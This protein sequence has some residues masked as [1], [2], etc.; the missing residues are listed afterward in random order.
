MATEAEVELERIRSALAGHVNEEI[1]AG[2]LVL[3]EGSFAGRHQL[4]RWL[5]RRF[6][7]EA[8]RTYSR[9]YLLALT[10]SRIVLFA[11][12]V[13]GSTYPVTRPVGEWG[14]GEVTIE[15]RG[16]AVESWF[17]STGS[18]YRSRV[19]SITIRGQDGEEM[20]LEAPDGR[21]S[22]AVLKTL[23]EAAGQA[24]GRS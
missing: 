23:K 17:A 15:S 24:A 6:D 1:V 18:H 3:G 10:P 16:H 4:R 12:R 2:R 7:A 11:C 13:K 21:L 5:R 9:Y 20:R 14:L 22:R 19:Q 8:R